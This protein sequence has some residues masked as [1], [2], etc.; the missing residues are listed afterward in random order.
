[1]PGGNLSVRAD[2]RAGFIGQTGSGK[3]FAAGLLC[4]N[5]DKLVVLDPKGSPSIK[6]W[7]LKEWDWRA[8][9]YLNRSNSYRLHVGPQQRTKQHPEGNWDPFLEAIWDAGDVTLYID[10]LYLITGY[11]RRP[12]PRLADLYVAGRERGIGTWGCSQRPAWTPRFTRSECEW[13]F[14][15]RLLDKDD[16]T[17]M[18]GHMGLEPLVPEKHPHGLWIFNNSWA[19]P[20]YYERLVTEREKG[21]KISV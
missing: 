11:G 14:S 16:R 15:F 5:V 6:S 19:K 7:G 21:E 1:M 18:R 9:Y 2:D 17:T 12:Q 8:P 13:L 3:T 4:A 10:E 20:R